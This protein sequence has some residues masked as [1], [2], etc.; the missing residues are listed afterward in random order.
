MFRLKMDR[1]RFVCEKVM[2]IGAH[3]E[4]RCEGV[5]KEEQEEA[6]AAFQEETLEEALEDNDSGMSLGE[7][8]QL[9]VFCEPSSSR[10]HHPEEN[11]QRR[12]SQHSHVKTHVI[13]YYG[14]S[15]LFTT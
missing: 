15:V 1:D 13:G 8:L 4:E 6:E 9:S 11:A 5:R 7:L 12:H 14:Q 10:H 2:W 3:D